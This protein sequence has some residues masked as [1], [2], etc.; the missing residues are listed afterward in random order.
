MT[1]HPITP[2][3]PLV[4]LWTNLPLCE[5]E[6]LVVAAQWGADQELK[7][8]T[9]WLKTGPYGASI[10]FHYTKIISDLRAARR[11]QEKTDLKNQALKA[12]Y[13][14]LDALKYEDHSIILYALESI[15]E[16]LPPFPRP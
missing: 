12:L 9:E 4:L 1:E 15:P 11:P 10:A 7:A 2:P 13:R 8:C 5:E 14:N 3:P 16:N 6:R